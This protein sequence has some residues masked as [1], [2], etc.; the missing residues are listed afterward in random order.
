MKSFHFFL[1]TA[2]SISCIASATDVVVRTQD[3]EELV[4]DVD[5]RENFFA[6]LENIECLYGMPSRDFVIDYCSAHY[7]SGLY[8][9]GVNRVYENP[10]PSKDKK[11]I[12]YIVT[13]LA[14]SSL[15]KLL[16]Q[17]S[18]LKKAGDRVAHVHPLSFLLA[19]FTDE[20]LKVGVSVIRGRSFVWSDFYGGL[21]ESFNDEVRKGNVRS[22]QIIDFSHQL[23]VDSSHVNGYIAEQRWSDLV[24]YL[25]TTLPRE[26]N[27]DRYDM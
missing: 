21:A 13:T 9:K 23:C 18:S 5:P 25:I 16:S 6:A 10:I 19:I 1:C 24:D 14:K 4:V 2:L 8:A 3:G 7:D 15:P 17:K 12:A 20:E 11:E 26:G 27:P 22:D